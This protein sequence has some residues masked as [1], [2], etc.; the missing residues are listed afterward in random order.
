MQT[1]NDR[2]LTTHS[3]SLPR[4][5][6]LVEL[7]V[8]LSRGERVDD[9]ELQDA[10]VSST[11]T[12]VKNQ[13]EVGIDIGNNGEQPRESFF[14]YVQHRMTGFGGSSSSPPF[15]D[16]LRYPSW[17]E[18]KLAGY[19][20]GVDLTAAPQAV[21]EVIYANEKPLHLEL[22]Q[23]ASLLD[24]E[25]NPFTE[26]FMT[27]PSPGIV[28]TAMEDTFYGD[29]QSY[30]DA[31][32][33]ALKTEYDAIYRAGHVLQLD[34]PDLAMERHTYF[35]ERSEREFIEFIDMVID[36]IGRALSDV[37][38]E[39]VRMH[40]C[41]GNYN[42]PHDVDVPLKSILPS[43]INANVGALMLSMANPRHAHE[44]R[45]LTS[46]NIPDEMLIVAGVI[47]TT[48]NYVEHPEVVADRIEAIVATVG[49]PRRVIAG[50]D[51]GFDTAAGLRD[52]A[53]EVV[54]AKLRA[55]VEGAEIASKRL[56]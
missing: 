34:C 2:F 4:K 31:L 36:A 18:L 13:I 30:V 10:V 38:K 32:A 29:M 35:G 7:Q 16:I 15:Q 55:L 54:W 14:T 37:P 43:L 23:F 44:Y 6:L 39:F 28:A 49:D 48:T 46:E 51:C 47:D 11:E 24:N 41:W 40:V 21:D 22:E 17:M 12:V 8:A 42:G 27:A 33:T 56:F 45:L 20:S 26:T 3:G 53:E 9:R 1:T 25:G 5:D 50:T 19:L 52:V